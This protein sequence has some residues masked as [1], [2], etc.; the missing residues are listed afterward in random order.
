MMQ[1]V[2][3]FKAPKRLIRE[4]E[5]FATP[6]LS[7]SGEQHPHQLSG[8]TPAVGQPCAATTPACNYEPPPPE[9]RVTFC[10]R[11]GAQG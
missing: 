11:H 3:N 10:R 8:Y 2:D 1:R 7:R 6:L 4:R 5:A 9:S